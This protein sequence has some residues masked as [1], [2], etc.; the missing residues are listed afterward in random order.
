MRWFLP[1]L[2][3]FVLTLPMRAQD[4][5]V[6]IYG[7][8][9]AGIAAAIAAADDGERVLLVEPTRRIGGMVTNGLSHPDFRTF[10]GLSGAFLSFSKLVESYYREAYGPDSPQLKDCFRGTQAEPKV[11]LLVFEKMLGARPKIVVKKQWA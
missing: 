10:E 5:D 4:Y 2:L 1:S 9:P 6:L 3:L 8:T 11:N 7:A